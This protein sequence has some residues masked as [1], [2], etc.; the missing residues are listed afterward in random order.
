L[1]DQNLLHPDCKNF[2]LSFWLDGSCLG[3]L[4]VVLGRYR[5][6]HKPGDMLVSDSDPNI[7]ALREIQT[8]ISI[9]VSESA[10]E[11]Y[12]ILRPIL[13]TEIASLDNHPDYVF[14]WSLF[15]A[16]NM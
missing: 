2:Y 1:R 12:T 6:M 15:I 9:P 16:D 13:L 7:A 4:G 11:L 10:E 5:I 3:S 8:W 14:D